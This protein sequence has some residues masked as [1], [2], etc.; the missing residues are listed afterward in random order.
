MLLLVIARSE[1]L[2]NEGEKDQAEIENIDDVA[3][4]I[5]VIFFTAELIFGF[6]TFF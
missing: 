2:G 3:D 5:S 4:C 1:L 6:C